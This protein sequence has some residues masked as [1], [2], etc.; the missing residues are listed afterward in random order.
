MYLSHKINEVMGNSLF[1]SLVSRS[2]L[3]KIN[4]KKEITV[5]YEKYYLYI[6]TVK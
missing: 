1:H 5:C 6:S 4:L 3:I 2:Q